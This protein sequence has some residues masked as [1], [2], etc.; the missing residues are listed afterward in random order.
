MMDEVRK[1][2]RR[3]GIDR[4]D[5]SIETREI[6]DKHHVFRQGETGDMAFLI[7]SGTVEIVKTTGD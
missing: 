4:R 1:Q 5:H 6:R 7:A 3:A 2:D